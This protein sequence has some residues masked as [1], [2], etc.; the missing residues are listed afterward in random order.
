[1]HLL[2]HKL[3]G[4]S[5]LIAVALTAH[6]VPAQADPP[7][8]GG[9]DQN[10]DGWTIN[11]KS[12]HQAVSVPTEG[13]PSGKPYRRSGESEVGTFRS[14]VFE[15]T[16][17]FIT[18]NCAGW[19]GQEG[20]L[21]KSYFRL[22]KANT[23]EV[24][25]ESAPP[26]F[27]G[28][29]EV[30][31]PVAQFAGQDVY[32]EAVD[33]VNK[34]GFAWIGLHDLHMGVKAISG[35]DS[36][37]QAVKL[38]EAP[39]IWSITSTTGAGAETTPYL[40]SRMLG[41]Q[42]TGTVCS[43]TF[44]V[45]VPEIALTLRGHDTQGGGVGLNR[46]ELVDADTG[47]VLRTAAPPQSDAATP[48]ALK[49]ADLTGKSVF[50]RLTDDCSDT[51]YAWLGIDA[52]DAGSDFSVDFADGP[53]ALAGWFSPGQ[54]NAYCDIDGV[55]FLLSPGSALNDGGMVDIP[56]GYP[57]KRLFLAGLT[58]SI[59]QGFVWEVFESRTLR[60]FLG[61][62]LGEVEIAYEDGSSDV[63]SL[64]L[65]D[66]VWF[67]RIITQHPEPFQSYPE[68]RAIR[69]ASLN[70]YPAEPRPDQ[71]YL[72]ALIT[73]DLAIDHV[74]IRDLS[75]KA[76]APIIRGITVEA[77]E[78][79][80][81]PNA[82]PLGHD[83][84]EEPLERYLQEKGCYPDS[85]AQNDSQA[86]VA[87]LRNLLYTT[88]QNFPKS[89]GAST[90]EGYRGPVVRFEGTPEAEV[91]GNIYH[92][93][94]DDMDHKVD[95]KGMYHTSTHNA[96][97]WGGYNGIGT[98]H[99]NWNSYYEQVWARDMGRALM[100]LIEAGVTDKARACADYCI[101]MG[102]VWEIGPQPE[103]GIKNIGKPLTLNG[104]PIPF[105]W[106]RRLNYPDTTKGEMF[107]NDSHGLTM[108]FLYNLWKRIPDRDEWLRE[109]WEW[110]EKGGDWIK[111]QFDNPE[112]S[113]ATE[114][115]IHTESESSGGP[116]FSIYPDYCC[117]EGLRGFA[118]MA[119]SIGEDTKAEEWRA[120]ADRLRKG[121]A[122]DYPEE[123]GQYGTVWTLKH[124]GWPHHTTVL[125]PVILG[126]DR[127]G[128]LRHDLDADFLPITEASFHR[129]VDHSAHTVP[130]GAYG[131]AMGYSQGF[132][133]QSAL[134]L[135][136]M[137]DA[138]KMLHWT[139]RLTYYDVPDNEAWRY[140]VPEGAEIHQSG[141]YWFRTGDL[142]NGVQEAETVKSVR[143]VLGIDSHDGQHLGLYPRLPK[144]WT[145]A[146]VSGY[147]ILIEQSGTR[148][149]ESIG[150]ALERTSHGMTFDVSLT[151]VYPYDISVRLG[152]F[153]D[154]GSDTTVTI[155]GKPADTIISSSGDSDWI[156]LT[157]PAGTEGFR[158]EVSGTSEV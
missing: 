16:G 145:K 69:D 154:L 3:T 140:I 88:P 43:P 53:P 129:V 68:A 67:A 91:L 26:Q 156:A 33:G 108:L 57:V 31:F 38:N 84:I 111:W 119:E 157:V 70:V 106:D 66:N 51:T 98:W 124:S 63:Y 105:H 27:D 152:S 17:D 109:R 40:S 96:P 112:L 44:V 121:M 138:Q 150:Y 56:L 2:A 62:R 144:E 29:V 59:E 132:I 137:A 79:Q 10:W 18:F 130:R 153:E 134:L 5:I 73:R 103:M 23:G 139:A 9:P 151:D 42:M 71:T 7:A 47:D 118:E 30:T 135:D 13:S 20:G 24:L 110:I 82:V 60:F 65:G 19:D 8:W 11:G 87:R 21:G 72:T 125:A 78:G 136:E 143:L 128:Y 36:A 54:G 93:N 45:R 74:R 37:F 122:R 28:L 102:Q 39:G 61:D 35:A 83:P 34:P 131:S 113:L 142:G 104:H 32:F 149:R 58:N 126:P 1:M 99:P 6:A 101:M 55:P 41:E 141:G 120:L 155:D 25:Y 116:G 46:V 90:P 15:L 14:P 50:I 114:F 75:E 100:E 76:G 117:M 86:R 127:T 89:V 147:P 80:E 4:W 64:T 94:L 146:T 95:E 81:L 158:I 77:E 52:V 22:C 49:T 85:F 107:D 92:F 48:V 115:H 148:R 123:D 97:S 12:W 133:T